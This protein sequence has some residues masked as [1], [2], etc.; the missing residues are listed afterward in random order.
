MVR[1]AEHALTMSSA[2]SRKS[3]LFVINA[4]HAYCSREAMSLGSYLAQRS[5]YSLR[6]SSPA[7]PSAAVSPDRSRTTA[8]SILPGGRRRRPQAL[9]ASVDRLHPAWLRRAQSVP[10]PHAASPRPGRTP[11]STSRAMAAPRRSGRGWSEA[12]CAAR[13]PTHFQGRKAAPFP[14]RAEHRSS[15]LEKGQSAT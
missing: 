8:D 14:W 3:A 9:P 1:S 2:L 11:L 7:R 4:A 10:R 15:C 5:E 6:A 13:S 12:R